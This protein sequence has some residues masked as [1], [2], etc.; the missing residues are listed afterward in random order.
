[1]DKPAREIFHTYI[2]GYERAVEA[3]QQRF[4]EAADILACNQISPNFT[5]AIGEVFDLDRDH[6][7]INGNETGHV[8]SADIL[9]GIRRLYEQGRLKGRVW[10]AGSTP[11]AFGAGLL[12]C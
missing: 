4:G 8:G 3:A 5:N 2:Q 12:E 6:V 9:I 10:M 11:Y 1:M 7:S